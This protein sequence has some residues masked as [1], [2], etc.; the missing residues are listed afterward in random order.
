MQFIILVLCNFIYFKLVETVKKK[1]TCTIRY[2]WVPS[3]MCLTCIYSLW[4]SFSTLNMPYHCL[5]ATVSGAKPRSLQ[6]LNCLK[7]GCLLLQRTE[8]GFS[9]VWSFILLWLSCCIWG[10]KSSLRSEQIRDSAGS[11][12]MGHPSRRSLGECH[13]VG[14]WEWFATCTI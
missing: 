12:P 7:P 3:Y 6:C 13:P 4:F 1:T 10:Q 14:R 9:T 11:T 8:N 2:V 5:W